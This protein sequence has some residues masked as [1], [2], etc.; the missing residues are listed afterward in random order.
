M[1]KRYSIAFNTS[2]APG[3][4]KAVWV[5]LE[6]WFMKDR[7]VAH[8]DLVNHPLYADLERYVLANPSNT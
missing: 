2:E 6:E 8:V 7:D 3:R 1:A 5:E 4:V